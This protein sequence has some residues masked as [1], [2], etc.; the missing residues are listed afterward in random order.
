MA[1]IKKNDTRSKK[2]ALLVETS[3]LSRVVIDVDNNF[4]EKDLS[5]EDTLTKA[6]NAV[7][8]QIKKLDWTDVYENII[9]VRE[10]TEYPYQE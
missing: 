5:S 3:I 9:S 2:I 6:S 4:S 10:D 7:A 8:N 1:T